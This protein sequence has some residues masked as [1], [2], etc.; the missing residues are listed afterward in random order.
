MSAVAPECIY[1]GIAFSLPNLTRKAAFARAAELTR[2]AVYG[3]PELNGEC[4]RTAA[5]VAN[6]GCYATSVILALAPLLKA[7]VIVRPMHGYGLTNHVRVTLGK[8]EEMEAFWKA[9]TPILDNVGCG[10]R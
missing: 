6:P 7:G 5:L 9:V 2:K 1:P 4:V 8:P 3:R 10:C